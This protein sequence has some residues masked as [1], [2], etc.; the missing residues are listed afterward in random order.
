MLGA[1]TVPEM[2]VA[3][4]VCVAACALTALAVHAA[5][6]LPERL[7]HVLR[8]HERFRSRA[9]DML[10]ALVVEAPVHGARPT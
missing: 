6:R 3:R 4:L 2:A 10:L 9:A 5:N 8:H 7:F 1:A